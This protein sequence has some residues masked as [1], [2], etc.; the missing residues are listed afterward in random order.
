MQKFEL[1]F[2]LLSRTEF[3]KGIVKRH[4]KNSH[5][6]NDVVN[7][8]YEKTLEELKQYSTDFIDIECESITG[9]KFLN[10]DEISNKL[11]KHLK[12]SVE[13]I[14]TDKKLIKTVYTQNLN[15]ILTKQI[16]QDFGNQVE[17]YLRKKYY[18]E[19]TNTWWFEKGPLTR[20]STGSKINDFPRIHYSEQS[21][22]KNPNIHWNYK[23]I[24]SEN[25]LIKFIHSPSHIRYGNKKTTS[26]ERNTIV[27]HLINM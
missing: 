14:Q 11:A 12:I 24:D 2:T 20:R 21:P 5:L 7:K 17:I 23:W 25:K 4:L 10:E 8:R 3:D 26:Y 27:N 13:T 18:G 9:V 1:N 16:T 15:K 19:Q 6:F 22:N